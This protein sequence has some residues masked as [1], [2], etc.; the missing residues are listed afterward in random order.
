MIDIKLTTTLKQILH[1]LPRSGNLVLT[2]HNYLF[3]TVDD[4]YIHQIF[5]LLKI[6]DL[7]KPDYFDHYTQYMGA[8]ISVIYPEEQVEITDIDQGRIIAFEVI[9]LFSAKIKP[10]EYFVLKVNSPELIAMRHQYGLPDKLK[11][12]GCDLDLHITVGVREL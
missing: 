11:L 8:H 12:R 2:D 4:N 6:P 3:L 1:Q 5:P 7:K 10:K 9:G